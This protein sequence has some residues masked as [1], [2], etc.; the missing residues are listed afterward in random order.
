MKYVEPRSIEEALGELSRDPDARCIAGGMTL[1]AMMNAELVA[2]TTLVALHRIPDLHG[3]RLEPDGLRI[4]ALT[5]HAMLAAESR[6]HGAVAVVRSAAGQIAHAP[7]RNRGTIGGA[8]SHG[9]PAADLPAALVAA[10][11]SMEICSTAGKRRIPAR[12]FFKDYLQTALEPGELVSAVF[13]PHGSAGARGRYLKFA[14]TDGDY[15]I[16]SIAIVLREIDGRCREARIVIGA[17]ASVPLQLD[18]ADS[19]LI[20]STLS[21]DVIAHAG[22]LLASAADPVDDVRGSAEYRRLLIP[23]LLGRAV[24]LVHE[25]AGIHD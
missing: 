7:I 10:D 19:E 11:A 8:V 18:A 3:I 9:D 20:G 13:V 4:G 22:E 12:Q 15:A 21:E 25:Q 17:V 16:V 1:V 5:T 23:R 24:T 6:L 2:P 14:R